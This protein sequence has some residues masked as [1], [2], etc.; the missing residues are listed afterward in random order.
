MKTKTAA[1][2][3]K[4]DKP[5]KAQEA[6]SAAAKLAAKN[7]VTREELREAGAAV[8]QEAHKASKPKPQAPIF[9]IPKRDAE[10]PESAPSEA[11]VSEVAVPAPGL[12]LPHPPVEPELGNSK[13]ITVV[14]GGKKPQKVEAPK[15][16][17]IN[18]RITEGAEIKE[19]R[20]A[21]SLRKD[22]PGFWAQGGHYKMTNRGKEFIVG[23]EKHFK[24][25]TDAQ[26]YCV[27]KMPTAS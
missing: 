18:K 11:P 25:L 26:K 8:I 9:G 22:Y 16:T 27:S 7:K 21:R 13:G 3:A 2:P 24:S 17:N 5:K 6:L 20:T 10:E 15:V 19:W 4:P 12:N 14:G 1:K 23:E